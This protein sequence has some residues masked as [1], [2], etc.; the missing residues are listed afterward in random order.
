MGVLPRARI[1][2]S[3]AIEV[4]DA[5]REFY[6]AVAQPDTA[7]VVFFA[8]IEFDGDAI[9]EQMRTAFAGVP[10]IGCTTAGEFGPAGYRDR[11]LSGASLPRGSFAA[12]TARIADVDSFDFEQAKSLIEQMWQDLHRQDPSAST[13]TCFAFLLIDG[14]SVRE[15]PVTLA[16]QDALRE[17]PLVGGSAGDGLAFGQTQVY[18]DGAFSS[19]S[20]VLAL[21]TTRLP[22]TVFKTQH[23]VPIQDRAVVTSADAEHRLIKQ[24]DG[25]PAAEG[26]ARLVGVEE[27]S[28]DPMRFAAQPVVVLIDGTSYVR[29]IQKVNPDGS[30]TLFCAIEEGIVLRAAL[31]VDLVGNLGETFTEINDQVGAPQLV[32]GCDCVLRKLEI[33]DSGLVSKVEDLFAANNVVGFN[34]YGE[35]FRGVHVNQTLTGI[36]VGTA[37]D[38][39]AGQP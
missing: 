2:Q 30:L 14:M 17:V 13:N 18:G 31:G 5:V 3:C 19:G 7:L 33:V 38:D 34:S 21:V 28:L 1:G 29:S 22:F 16:L 12:V 9:A 27:D 6:D 36:A 11:S 26:Y 8:S 20:A 15:E 35:Q 32:L 4:R 39:G 25:R 24:I 37:P 23:F 10:V